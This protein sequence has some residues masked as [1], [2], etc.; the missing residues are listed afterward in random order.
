MILVEGYR[1][2]DVTKQDDT[3]SYSGAGSAALFALK[4]VVLTDD[5]SG[6]AG[7]TRM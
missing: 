6:L 3:H 1:G 4:K 5:D 2:W 7:P